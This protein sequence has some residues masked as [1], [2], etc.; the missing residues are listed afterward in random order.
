MKDR[1]ISRYRIWTDSLKEREREK[2]RQ[3]DKETYRETEKE[4]EIDELKREI[5][6]LK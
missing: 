6:I 5:L 1:Q 3:T 4:R 2:G